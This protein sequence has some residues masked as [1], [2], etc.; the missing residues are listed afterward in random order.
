MFLC[1]VE[2]ECDT[3]GFS[4]NA[5]KTKVM[6]FQCGKCGNG[7][8]V[9]KINQAVVEDTEEQDFKYLGPIY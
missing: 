7:D 6:Y 5:K 1:N 3:V 4:L 8:N 9:K 2:V